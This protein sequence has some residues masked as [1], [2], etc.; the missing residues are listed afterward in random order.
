MTIAESIA[1]H[2]AVTKLQKSNDR[3]MAAAP[4]L[5]A[6]LRQIAWLEP[7]DQLGS[8]DVATIRAAIAKATGEA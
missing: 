6:A 3:L 8:G 2:A 5:L 4:D 7:G 1:L